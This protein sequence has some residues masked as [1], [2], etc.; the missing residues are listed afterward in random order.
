VLVGTI[1][2]VASGAPP[3]RMGAH[4]ASGVIGLASYVAVKAARVRV[5]ASGALVAAFLGVA[6]VAST[7]LA[8][9]I[10]G[11]SRWYELGP[12]R[13]HPSALLAPSLLV[14]AAVHASTRPGR[15]HVV[16]ALLQVVHV[17]Q[18]DAGQATA[19][20]AAAVVVTLGG[21]PGPGRTGGALAYGLSIA[22]AWLRPDPLPPAPFVEDIVWRAFALAP[23]L[24]VLAVLS[25]LAFTAAPLVSGGRASLPAAVLAQRA[26]AAYFV[27][28]LLAA[29]AGEFPIPLLGLGPSPTVGAFL[30]LGALERLRSNAVRGAIVPP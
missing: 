22:A 5:P 10:G 15:A 26:L 27:G 11:V 20:G 21:P 17:L 13:L 8:D 1:V 25:L 23:A 24:G 2:M 3:A 12:L 14:F 19:L 16:M 9:G 30:G 7:L 6:A 4:V 18:P 28:S 29:A